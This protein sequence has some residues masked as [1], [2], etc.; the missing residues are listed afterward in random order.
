MAITMDWQEIA[1][2]YWRKIG[3]SPEKTSDKEGGWDIIDPMYIGVIENVI[4]NA[5]YELSRN[6]RLKVKEDLGII[7][8]GV[9]SYQIVNN[10]IVKIKRLEI[11]GKR[12]KRT[13][14]TNLGIEN[15][16]LE[17]RWYVYGHYI[18]FTK[19]IEVAGTLTVYAE[20]DFT[21]ANSTTDSDVIDETM[22]Y[23]AEVCSTYRIFTIFTTQLYASFPADFYA[24]AWEIS[25][26]SI[27]EM[28]EY[29]RRN[30]EDILKLLKERNDYRITYDKN[31]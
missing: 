21:P 1:E 30:Y 4:K 19:E 28:I 15:D 27:N 8:A 13:T 12:I 7:T 23:I 6:I 24:S 25:G 14:L 26:E 20:K 17:I 29:K 3:G 5:T 2:R 22:E 31:I 16:D 10:K 9:R 11:D 18:Y